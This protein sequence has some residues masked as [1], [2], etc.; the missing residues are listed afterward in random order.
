MDSVLQD[1]RHAWRRVRR[2]PVFA[3]AAVLTLALG[4]GANTA[5]FSMLNAL[6]LKRLP[7]EDP[8][9][10]IA[11]AP[12]TSR[13]LPGSTPVSAVDELSRGGPLQRDRKGASRQSVCC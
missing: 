9:G 11:I 1:L 6:V 7:I 2:S 3:C 5:M 12:R 13:G 10:L 8:D 4:I